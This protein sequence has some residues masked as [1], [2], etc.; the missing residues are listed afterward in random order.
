ML[1]EQS[2]HIVAMII[3][4]TRRG[5][6]CLEPGAEAETEWLETM[7]SKRRMIQKFLSS[8]T[9]GY[10]NNEGK[11]EE[12]RGLADIYGG[13][14]VEFYGMLEKWRDDGEMRGLEFR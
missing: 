14:P 10:Y 7:R 12:G 11:P 9:P 5:A 1:D 3:E 8:C 6:T 13:G 2:R 4:A